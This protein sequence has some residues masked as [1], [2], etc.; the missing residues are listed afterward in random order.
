MLRPFMRANRPVTRHGDQEDDK[1]ID[2]KEIPSV[3]N[4]GFHDGINYS[5]A[6]KRAKDDDERMPQNRCETLAPLLNGQYLLNRNFR[7]FLWRDILRRSRRVHGA[8]QSTEDR[9]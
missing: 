7:T 9:R 8:C 4:H 3:F 6:G 1:W 5:N 2:V